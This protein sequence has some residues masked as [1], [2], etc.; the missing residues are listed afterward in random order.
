M[1]RFYGAWGGRGLNSMSLKM[2][3]DQKQT[4]NARV[5]LARGFLAYGHTDV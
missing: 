3:G 1:I 2:H 5:G 4:R